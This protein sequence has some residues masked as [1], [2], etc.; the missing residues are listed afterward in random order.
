MRSLLIAAAVLCFVPAIAMAQQ[1][2]QV[3]AGQ[4]GPYEVHTWQHRTH[5]FDRAPY[6]ATNPP[7][8]YGD[9]RLVRS[10]GW[11]PYPYFGSQYPIHQAVSPMVDGQDGAAALPPAKPKTEKKVRKSLGA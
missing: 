1:P 6:F 7:V 2:V 5:N 8:Y 11:T 4:A 3:F 9:Q 10:Y